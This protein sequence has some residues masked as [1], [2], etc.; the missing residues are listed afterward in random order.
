M[1][2]LISVLWKRTLIFKIEKKPIKLNN[3]FKQLYKHVDTILLMT[4]LYLLIIIIIL[5]QK[6]RLQVHEKFKLL[7]FEN[8]MK[9]EFRA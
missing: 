1:Y 8:K 2:T 6:T 3:I 5:K 4:L 7:K 9:M